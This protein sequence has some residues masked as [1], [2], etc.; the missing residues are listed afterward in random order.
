MDF[1]YNRKYH[2]LVGVSV[3]L[4]EI[5]HRWPKI[6]KLLWGFNE[7]IGMIGLILIITSYIVMIS[8][9]FDEINVICTTGGGL[10]YLIQIPLKMTIIKSNQKIFDRTVKNISEIS[11]M[12]CE[13]P[14]KDSNYHKSFE[15]FYK[16]IKILIPVKAGIEFVSFV[17]LALFYLG[18]AVFYDKP[19]EREILAPMW[20]SVSFRDFGVYFGYL[21]FQTFACICGL[22][23][24][25]ALDVFFCTILITIIIQL[26]YLKKIQKKM[27]ERYE[28]RR[29]I[30]LRV[31][32]G[33]RREKLEKENVEELESNLKWWIEAHQK[34][35][36]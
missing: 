20:P 27:I 21:F 18:K 34:I 1:N 24:N 31:D 13:N 25:S 14:I 19:E 33:S 36:R 4:P 22:L 23:R 32:D 9:H 12:L 29:K 6:F 28:E 5:F 16:R 15:K 7:Y 35:L 17:V 30:F 10:L 2:L 11:M 8:L 3:Y 26:K